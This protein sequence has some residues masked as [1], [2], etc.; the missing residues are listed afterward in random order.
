[1][2]I[3]ALAPLSGKIGPL[4]GARAIP[5]PMWRYSHKPHVTFRSL[6][7][8]LYADSFSPSSSKL[9]AIKEI[10][11]RFIIIFITFNNFVFEDEYKQPKACDG[12]IAVTFTTRIYVS[13]YVWNS[14]CQVQSK[15][16]MQIW[17]F[18]Y[19]TPFDLKY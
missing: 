14:S 17:I 8:F 18:F 7:I 12:Y 4:K 19:P 10:L 5:S 3:E 11:V 15:G 16:K 1:M 6:V 9:Y 13:V 2:L